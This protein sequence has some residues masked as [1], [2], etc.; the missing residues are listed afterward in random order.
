MTQS[1]YEKDRVIPEQFGQTEMG[2]DL[3][4]QDYMLKQLTAS[5]MYPDEELGEEFWKHV[6]AKAQA[7]YGTTEIP[8]NTF[9]KVWIVP[10]RAE[11]YVHEQNV[12]VVDSYLK[13][14]MEEDYESAKWSV[15]SGKQDKKKDTALTTKILPLSRPR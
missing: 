1:P 8:M 9:N 14:M 12:F 5:L 13:V 11:V 7:E 3:L 4:A 2:R 10:E 15:V 6:Y